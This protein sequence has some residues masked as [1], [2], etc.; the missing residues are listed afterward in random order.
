MY[1]D[2]FGNDRYRVNLHMHTT[3]SDGRVEPKEAERI[4]RAAGYDAIAITDHWVYGEEHKTEDGLLV[5]S[6]AEYN[7]LGTT[8][9]EGLFHI[10]GFGMKTKPVIDQSA[11]AQGAIDAIKAAGGVA[12]IA[13]PAWSLNTPEHILPLTG[14]DATEIYNTISGLY[15]SRRADSSLIVDMLGAKGRFYPLIAADD[16]HRYEADAC[17][18]YVMVKAAECTSEAICKA[19]LDGD[20]YA[21]EGP[22]VHIWREGDEIVARSSPVQEIV[23]LSD[24][25]WSRRAFTADGITEARYKISPT[26]TFVRAEVTDENGLRAWTNIIILN[27]N[28]TTA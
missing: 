10:V 24:S 28:K 20:F 19:I 25:V 17:Y 3:L 2:I 16:T 12:V 11:D 15:M 18:A 13:H 21:S 7:I 8:S 27:E 1:K 9:R 14:A 4:Y 26:D 22:E 23:F 6:G 5:L